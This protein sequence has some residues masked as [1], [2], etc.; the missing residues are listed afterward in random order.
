MNQL[1]VRAKQG[2]KKS[3][4]E[5]LKNF[6]PLVYKTSISYYIYGYSQEDIKQIARLTIIESLE[7]F[8]TDLSDSF[9][10][11]VQKCIKNKMYKEIEKATNKYYENKLNKEIAS[12]INVEEIIDQNTDVSEECIKKELS[13]ILFKSIEMLNEDEKALLNSI[14]VQGITLKEYS[15]RT[16]IE[17][18]K[19]R[20]M[21]DKIM[22]KLRNDS[23][24][25]RIK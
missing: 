25:L 20:Y 10:A 11:Y 14:Y 22:E 12:S 1:I 17:Y 21:K 6:E 2:D 15:K 4:E 3:M 9:P 5:I 23:N 7:K 18:H 8:N 16:N 13:S 19:L 24:I